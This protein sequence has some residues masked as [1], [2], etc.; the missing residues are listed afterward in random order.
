MARKLTLFLVLFVIASLHACGDPEETCTCTCTC[1]SGA[2]DTIDEAASED[3]CS[4][5]CDTMCG[6]DSFTTNYDCTTKG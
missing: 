6:N 3:D 2:K 4:S 5:R 1:G